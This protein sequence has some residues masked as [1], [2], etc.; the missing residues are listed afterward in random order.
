MFSKGEPFVIDYADDRCSEIWGVLFE[1]GDS[2]EII[3]SR[4]LTQEDLEANMGAG[5]PWGWGGFTT[6][7]LESIATRIVYPEGGVVLYERRHTAA[8][9]AA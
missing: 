3:L 6:S 8:M 9:R 4:G 7:W 2:V 5:G 1:I